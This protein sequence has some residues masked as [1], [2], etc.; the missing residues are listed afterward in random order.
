MKVV[1][2]NLLRLGFAYQ[3]PRFRNIGPNSGGLFIEFVNKMVGSSYENVK[4]ILDFEGTEVYTPSFLDEVVKYFYNL[5]EFD[6]YSQ[7]EIKNIKG[8]WGEFIKSSLNDY[9]IPINIKD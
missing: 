4:I 5:K 6:I 7:F 1:N 2:L 8:S 3:G 9:K